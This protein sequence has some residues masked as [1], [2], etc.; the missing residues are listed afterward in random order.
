MGKNV[1]RVFDSGIGTKAIWWYTDGL[2]AILGYGTIKEIET[3][4]EVKSATPWLLIPH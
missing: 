3:I 1:R 2:V 4:N